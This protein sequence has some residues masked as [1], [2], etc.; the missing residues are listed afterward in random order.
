MDLNWHSRVSGRA[1][2]F[3]AAGFF[4]GGEV[5]RWRE[6][7]RGRSLLGPVQAGSVGPERPRHRTRMTQALF[8]PLQIEQT[9]EFAEL[10]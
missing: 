3:L 5:A 1:F 9:R 6:S 2:S 7:P 4:N 10:V 8:P